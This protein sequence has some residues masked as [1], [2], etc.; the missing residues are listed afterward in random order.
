MP[1]A[2][3]GCHERPASQAR[4]AKEFAPGH[5]ANVVTR[6]GSD[7]TLLTRALLVVLP[8][9]T[10]LR[11]EVQAAR[12]CGTLLLLFVFLSDPHPGGPWDRPP[13]WF[14]PEQSGFARHAT[15]EASVRAGGRGLHL[16]F[17]TQGGSEGTDLPLNRE[18]SGEGW[19]RVGRGPGADVPETD[20]PPPTPTPVGTPRVWPPFLHSAH[21]P[22]LTHTHTHRRTRA[23]ASSHMRT[24]TRSHTRHSQLSPPSSEVPCKPGR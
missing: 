8:W 11:Q 24:H 21:T 15:A 4:R 12:T 10:R 19:G 13:S 16:P 18:Q 20:T 22:A 2:S 5:G 17:V 3:Y 7:R 23:C 14:S 6:L 9:T 1:G